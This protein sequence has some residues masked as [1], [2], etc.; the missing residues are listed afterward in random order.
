MKV[1]LCPRCSLAQLS[2]VV[3]PEVLYNRYLYVTSPSQ[4]MR[5]HFQSLIADIE[6]E[7]AGKVILEIGAN[8]GRL[9]SS[10]KDR[11]Y[12]V[13]GIDPAANLVEIANDN[14]IPMVLGFFGTESAKA[15]PMFDVVIAR[16]VFCHVD[17][18][19]DFVHGLEAVTH[20][21]S[22]ICLETPYVGDMLDN[23]EF[24]T[25]YHEHL[26]YLSIESIHMLLKDTSLFLYKIVKYPIHGGAVMLML[27]NRSCGLEPD[28]S[29]TGFVEMVGIDRW[30]EFADN[31]RDQINRL[32]STV[33]AAVAQ[34]KRVAALGASAKSTVWIN[35]CGFT[36]NEIEFIADNTPQKQ[37]TFSP[38]SGIPIVDEGA[39]IRELPS[40]V[41]MFCWNYKQEVLE[42]FSRERSQG[43]KFIVPVRTIEV[44]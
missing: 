11:G 19:K 1:M 38:G 7:N 6:S 18:W 8:D 33:G 9:L 35:A 10:F 34:K 28:K 4:T 37:L 29:V 31:C 5:Q 23:N 39:I 26:S 36:R 2:V 44:V 40:Y 22:I 12:S 42:K 13:T 43:V 25:I 3:D 21:D 32:R 14:G 30:R 16:H 17:D 24:D 20:K 41:V 27:R 15:L